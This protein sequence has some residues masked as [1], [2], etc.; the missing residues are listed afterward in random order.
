LF[1]PG[2]CGSFSYLQNS[3]YFEAKDWLN[4][5]K[6]AFPLASNRFNSKEDALKFV[7]NL[8]KNGA[9]G[10]YVI[11]VYQDSRTIKDENGPYADT[12]VV[13]LPP[14]KDNRKKLFDIY[15]DE[16]KREGFDTVSDFGQSELLFWWD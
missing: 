1:L 16:T 7:D 13:K 15:T 3:N 14:D 5:N 8:Y 4:E 10:V 11:N 2:R 9:Q 12:L 6:N